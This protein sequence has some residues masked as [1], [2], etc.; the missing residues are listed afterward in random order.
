MRARARLTTLLSVISRSSWEKR[1]INYVAST[2]MATAFFFYL[3]PSPLS[4]L[5]GQSVFFETGDTPQHVAGWLLYAKDAWRWPPL[6]TQMMNA[7][8]G[9]N[10]ALT[11]S[12]PLAA[13]LFKPVFPLLPENF[14][15][16]GIWHLL[17]KIVQAMGAVFLMRSLERRDLFSAVAAA[18]LALTWPAALFRIGHTALAGHGMLLIALS[19][20]FRTI[21]GNLTVTGATA[22]FGFLS[23]TGLLIHPYLFAMVFPVALAAAVDNGRRGA[24]PLISLLIPVGSGIIVILAFWLFGYS[25]PSKPDPEGYSFYS[26]NVLAPFCG[27]FLSPCGLQDATN[28]QYEGF[29]YLGA[30]TFLLLIVA[31]AT[32]CRSAVRGWIAKHLALGALLAG[33]TLYAISS[34]IFIGEFEL[35]NFSLSWP[36]TLITSVFRASGR[37]FWIV[38]YAIAFLA[39]GTVLKRAH[40]TLLCICGALILQWIDTSQ[41]RA[42]TRAMLQAPAPFDYSGWSRLASR[43]DHIVVTPVYGCDSSI[44]N[45]KYL[46]FQTVASRLGVPINTGYVAR[47]QNSCADG[48]QI[49]TE[50]LE[51]RTLRVYLKP[52]DSPL[53]IHGKPDHYRAGECIEW[54]DWHRPRLCLAG[55]T[56]VDWSHLGIR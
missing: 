55:A 15:Y 1:S 53:D 31:L 52:S 26:M 18:A 20:Y 7:P 29:N 5:A 24:P 13:L 22:A 19:L 37:F 10:I 33:F 32:S 3:Y 45:M 30:G 49:A 42:Q 48:K 46:Y 35:V 44:E 51:L 11:D 47:N 17:N 21:S 12:I 25:G 50:K 56:S 4:F 8:T 16:F 43:I 9:V 28:G 34:R 38:G 2:L 23:I 40:F 36:I 14:H 6:L 27:G 54:N 39:L 41:L